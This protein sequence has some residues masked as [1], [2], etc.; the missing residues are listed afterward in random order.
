MELCFFQLGD[1]LVNITITVPAGVSIVGTSRESTTIKR[2]DASD[3]AI[4][5]LKGNNY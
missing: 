2:T 1:Y 5:N 3:T 4:F